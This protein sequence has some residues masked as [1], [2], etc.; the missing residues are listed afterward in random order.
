MPDGTKN[1]QIFDASALIHFFQA[2]YSYAQVK[3]ILQRASQE[4][5]KVL[6]SSVNWGEVY[7]IAVKAGGGQNVL[8]ALDVLPIE[9]VPVDA[10]L[11]QDAGHCKA[12]THLPYADA[13]AFA[14]AK[15]YNGQLVTADKDFKVV[16]DQISIFWL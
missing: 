10:Q 3:S 14:L 16:E 2:Q 12:I 4:N 6:I 7:C 13:F 11:A 9:V 15:R 8:T 5:R 1:I